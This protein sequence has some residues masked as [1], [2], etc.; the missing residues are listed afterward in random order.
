MY[1]NFHCSPY[2]VFIALFNCFTTLPEVY[3]SDPWYEPA[4]NAKLRNVKVWTSAENLKVE[5][6]KCEEEEIEYQE[7]LQECLKTLWI[8]R[9]EKIPSKNNL[10]H[11]G[12]TL[13]KSFFIELEIFV[14]KQAS[15]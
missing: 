6:E 15:V 12:L 3:L 1:F 5:E 8:I 7:V 14:T 10:I 2:S 11:D 4:S 13:H 9:E